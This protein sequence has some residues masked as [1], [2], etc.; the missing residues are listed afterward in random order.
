MPSKNLGPKGQVVIPKRMREAVGIKPG[1]QV[2][3]EM[4]DNEIVITKST[5]K[6]TYTKYFISTVAPKLKKKVDIK[7]IISEEVNSRNGIP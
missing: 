3:L 1:S 5:V 6:G 4:R 2:I 7:K